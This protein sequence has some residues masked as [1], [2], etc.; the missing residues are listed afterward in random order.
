MSRWVEGKVVEQKPW[1][2]GLFSLF[3][4]AEIMPFIA[5]QFA[6]LSVTPHEPNIF[7][8]YSFAS[9]PSE[10]MLEFYYDLIAQGSLTP[11]LVEK[12]ACDPIWI[13]QKAAGKFILAEVPSAPTLWLIATGT[14]FG[15]F[16]SLLK[17]SE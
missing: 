16:L 9:A 14:G 1:A 8:P 17:T 11:T 7:C 4:Q 13:G 3:V 10:P 6:Q 15:V 5:G 12:Q 2:T